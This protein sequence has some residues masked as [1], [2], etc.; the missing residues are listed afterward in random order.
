MAVY[1]SPFESS[2][3]STPELSPAST[4]ILTP[5]TT[6]GPTPE[7]T[8]VS[9]PPPTPQPTP[10]S[11]PVSTPQPTRGS[12]SVFVPQPIAPFVPRTAPQTTPETIP[13]T[14]SQRPL[15]PTPRLSQPITAN[16]STTQTENQL[17]PNEIYKK[18]V[19]RQAQ[20]D[21]ERAELGLK[22]R[23]RLADKLEM[24]LW[25]LMGFVVIVTIKILYL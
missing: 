15:H 1:R 7:N 18:I 17:S 25:L 2:P 22:C 21:L 16:P 5:E 6:P 19:V 10:Q 8:P 13:Q 12:R 20:V 3:E 23:K 14:T 4:P 9:T 24:G 11:I